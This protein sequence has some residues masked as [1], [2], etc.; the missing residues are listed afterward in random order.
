LVATIFACLKIG[1]AYIPLDPVY[2]PE[3][4]NQIVNDAQPKCIV[5]YQSLKK[6]YLDNV[7]A[8]AVVCL[9]KVEIQKVDKV[10]VSESNDDRIAYIIF[11]SGTTGKPKGIEITHGNL[12]NLLKGFDVSFGDTDKQTWLAQ[13]SMNFDISVLELIWTISRG[14]TIVL[15]QSSPFKL[16]APERLSPAIWRCI[17]KSIGFRFSLGGNY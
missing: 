6:L 13:T 14:K 3:R 12:N 10:S 9:D 7:P 15:Q 1:A 2:P 11:T 5:T 4:L 8:E 17:S 16:L